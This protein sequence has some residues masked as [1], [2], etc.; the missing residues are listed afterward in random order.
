MMPRGAAR[1]SD[2]DTKERKEKKE[3]KKKEKKRRD[4]WAVGE[5]KYSFQDRLPAFP[6]FSKLCLRFRA[7]MGFVED[8]R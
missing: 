6:F 8:G 3:E 2:P 5:G 4:R 1:N 7:L